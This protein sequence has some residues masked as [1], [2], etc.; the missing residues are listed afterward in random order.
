MKFT[1]SIDKLYNGNWLSS[2]ADDEPKSEIEV[3]LETGQHEN[4]DKFLTFNVKLERVDTFLEAFLHGN[5][6]KATKDR[7][8]KLKLEEVAYVKE[9]KRAVMH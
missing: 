4:R 9:K 7:K 6:M 5:K 8:R 1:S 3:F 2:K